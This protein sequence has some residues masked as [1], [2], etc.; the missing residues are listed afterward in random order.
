MLEN[1]FRYEV[2][3]VSELYKEQ[4]EAESLKVKD[5]L[6]FEMNRA[7]RRCA[8]KGRKLDWAHILAELQGIDLRLVRQRELNLAKDK[9]VKRYMESERRDKSRD[10]EKLLCD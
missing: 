7:V 8:A 10:V 6:Q 5:R 1:A 2:G 4:K 9:A 3:K